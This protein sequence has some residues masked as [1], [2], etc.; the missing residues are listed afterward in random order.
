MDGKLNVKVATKKFQQL[1]KFFLSTIYELIFVSTLFIPD[2][3][4]NKKCIIIPTF[5]VNLIKCV[6]NIYI[7]KKSFLLTFSIEVPFCKLPS[8]HENRE[9][10]V[11]VFTPKKGQNKKKKHKYKLNSFPKERHSSKQVNILILKTILF[12]SQNMFQSV[13]T[14]SSVAKS[15]IKTVNII[16][17]FL[18]MLQC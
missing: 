15:I 7:E 3:F 4:D 1:F 13:H 11:F 9:Q 12:I 8:K 16:T 5:E 2:I 10:L 6:K 18:K 14:S 17:Y